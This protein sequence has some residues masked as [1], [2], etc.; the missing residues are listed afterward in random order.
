MLACCIPSAPC[1]PAPARWEHDVSALLERLLTTIEAGGIAALGLVMLVENLFPPIP[2]EAVLPL[3]GFAVHRGHLPF[4]LALSAATAGSL[5]GAV[6]LYAAGRFGGRPAVSRIAWL[7]LDGVKLDRADNWFKRHGS[8]LVFWGRMV[9]LMRSAVS[10]PAGLTGMPF[11]RFL[12]YTTLGSLVWNTLLIAAGFA[13]GARW[14]VV[15]ALA[16]RYSHVVLA[17][18]ALALAVA[19][20]RAGLR[21]RRRAAEDGPVIQPPQINTP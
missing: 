21:I 10:V 9:P 12:A 8:M 19:V 13:L 2:S 4:A 14:E 7:G 1:P 6:L 20:G 15:S 18:G 3:A 16:A 17:A 11:G 5:I